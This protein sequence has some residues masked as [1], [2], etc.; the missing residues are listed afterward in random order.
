[1]QC[2]RVWTA[3]CKI[4]PWTPYLTIFGAPKYAAP[5]TILGIFGICGS[6][7]ARQIWCPWRDIANAVQTRWHCVVHL[8]VLIH[9]MLKATPYLSVWSLVLPSSQMNLFLSL[10]L[11]SSSFWSTW[12]NRQ[13]LIS[14]FDHRCYIHLRWSCSYP[15]ILVHFLVLIHLM[16][17][18]TP[19]LSLFF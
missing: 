15:L 16:Q 8:H 13:L 11:F 10:S 1:M 4:S 9:L 2:Q 5:N 18:A 6:V 17:K 19:F 7:Y 3:F 12:C 14:L